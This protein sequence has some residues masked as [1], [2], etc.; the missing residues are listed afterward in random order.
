MTTTKSPT[1]VRRL[2]QSVAQS[3]GN[4]TSAALL[5]GVV[6]LVAAGVVKLVAGQLRA[7]YLTLLAIGLI[8]LLFAVATG[9]NTLRAT[10]IS[11]RG[12]YGF[13]TTIMILL[14]VV[15][16]AVIVLV[17]AINN[18]TF[19]T[20]ASKQFTLAQQSTKI[21]KDLNQDVEAVAFFA[22]TDPTPNDAKQRAIR[23]Q[24]Q[25]LLEEYRKGSSRF[26]YRVVDPDVEPEEA[27]RFGVN[28][29]TRPGSI[30]I[31]S[32]GNLQPVDTLL[33]TS[34]GGYQANN[35]LERDFTQSILAVTRKLQKVVYFTTRH[36]ERDAREV[37]DGNGYGLAAKELEGDNY[38]VRSVDIAAEKQMPEDAAV[39]VIAGPRKDLLDEEKEPLR[40]YLLK[41]GKALFLLDPDTPESYKV[42]LADWGVTLGKG[43]VIDP[44]SSVAGN[45]RAPLVLRARYLDPLNLNLFNPITRVLTDSTFFD[46]AGAVTPLDNQGA[47]HDPP[48][49]NAYY[50]SNDLNVT[51]LIMSSDLS[52]LGTNAQSTAFIPGETAG[53]LAIAVAVDAHAPFKQKALDGKPH[54]Q[55]VVVG[56]SAFATNRF[57][58]S[59][60]NGDFLANSVNWLAGDVELISVRPKL[61]EARILVVS[62]GTFNFI[63]WSSWLLL[64]AAVAS[65]GL[66]V[67][68]RRR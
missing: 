35:N 48:L 40:Q 22:P 39:I 7:S 67:W 1:P 37:L 9:Y 29:D 30:V 66:F 55:I 16:M 12:F 65:S 62:Q 51:P 18:V 17:G 60:A 31:T 47:H 44:G 56:N 58:S 34:Q 13:N 52:W 50:T 33:F 3:L 24:A 19:D 59:F 26:S 5:G 32:G 36:G 4:V 54:T 14:F 61:E 41:G 2:T 49:P 20:T 27:R 23:S 45:P 25:D 11:R 6:A 68:W 57:Y 63:R 28:P 53:P 42:L 8:L 43:M 46:Q 21:L 38:V 10:L 64:P 15:I